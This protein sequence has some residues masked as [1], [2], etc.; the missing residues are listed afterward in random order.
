[1]KTLKDLNVNGQKVLLRVDFNVPLTDNMQVKDN[2]RIKEAVPTIKYL[3]E[4]GGAKQVICL[5]HFGRPK[6]K[7][8]EE[9]RLAPVVSE[10][11]TIL[12]MPVGYSRDLTVP[13]GKVVLLENI[14]FYAGEEINDPEFSKQ[15]ASLADCYV[16]DAFGTAHRAHGSTAGVAELLPHAA[17]LLMQKEVE[18]LEKVLH[19]PEHPVVAIIGGA[20]IST[21]ISLIKN[22][23]PKVEY[24]L[25]GGALANTV[26]LAQHKQVGKSLVEKDLANTISDLVSNKLR[27]P[28][29]VATVKDIETKKDLKIKAVGAVIADDIILDIGPDTVNLYEKCI[30]QAKTI[31]WNGPMGLFEQTD[32][33]KG[34]YGVARAVADSDGY[35]VIGGGET[36]AA[37][38]NTGLENKISFIST[39]GGAMLEFLEGKTLPGIE[40]LE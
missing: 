30:Q 24:L 32:F 20:K 7:I 22:L 12:G 8:V 21:K 37:V 28:V 36:V 19:N 27:I 23:L 17:G 15:L 9:M 29:D 4:Q 6:G 34:T 31:I 35:S 18:N 3:L 33:A 26:L 10:L 13:E 16:N 5:A 38:K 40:A 11:E 1:M 25:L 39:G 14:R 2:T